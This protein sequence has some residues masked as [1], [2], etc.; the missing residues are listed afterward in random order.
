MK[1]RLKQ[2]KMSGQTSLV[3]LRS[4]GGAIMFTKVGDVSED[5]PDDVAKELLEK[6][7]G[8][9]EQEGKKSASAPKNKAARSPRKKSV[10]VKTEDDKKGE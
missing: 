1:L 4:D 3:C 9:L 10:A 5:L 6:F 2:F 8:L 7:D